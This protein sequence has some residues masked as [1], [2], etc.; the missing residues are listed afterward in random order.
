MATSRVTIVL[1]SLSLLAA[2][3]VAYPQAEPQAPP[4]KEPVKEPTKGAKQRAAPAAEATPEKTEATGV[5]KQKKLSMCLETWD[6]QT[7]M[8]KQQWRVACARSVR[9][10]PD[11]FDR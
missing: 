5:S 10:Y 1:A 8:T 4:T 11:A 9:D 3:S 7:H 2:S 6:A